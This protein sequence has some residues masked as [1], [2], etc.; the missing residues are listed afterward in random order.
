MNKVFLWIVV[1]GI[2]L[3]LAIF[4]L[5]S[6]RPQQVSLESDATLEENPFPVTSEELPSSSP[7]LKEKEDLPVLVLSPSEESEGK[8]TVNPPPSEGPERGKEMVPQRVSVREIAQNPHQYAGKIVILQGKIT[9]LCARGCTFT[10]EDGTGAVVVELV[11]DALDN[12]VPR[13]GLGR[14]VEV[15]GRVELSGGLRVV[16]ENPDGWRFVR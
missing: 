16:V 10:L 3:G 1:G 15:Q 8:A 4:L 14:W 11:G 13:T 7:E 5:Q 9:T 6:Q 2:I 12:L